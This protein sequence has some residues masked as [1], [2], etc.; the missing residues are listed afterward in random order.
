MTNRLLAAVAADPRRSALAAAAGL[1]ALGAAAASFGGGE[2]GVR[3]TRTVRA[4]AIVR[5]GADLADA[6]DRLGAVYLAER[7]AAEIAAAEAAAAPRPLDITELV[8]GSL[9]ALVHRD[10][11]GG[12][13]LWL[14]DRA[15]PAGA[16]RRIALGDEIADGW[17]VTE[18]ALQ[19][20]TVSRD[21]ESLE[22]P[23]YAPVKG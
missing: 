15:G 18:I 13:A 3:E 14:V 16:R 21:Q 10:G 11:D 22:I 17:R 23:V 12:R 20:V 9:T 7:R 8:R 1:F 4:P 6:A 19:S 2:S 5:P